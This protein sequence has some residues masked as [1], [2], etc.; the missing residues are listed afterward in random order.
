MDDSNRSAQRTSVTELLTIQELA[1]ALKIS[2]VTAY[3]MVEHRELPFFKIRGSLRFAGADVEAYLL[4]NRIES[5]ND[6]Q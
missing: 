6:W 1:K 4:R 2:T 3:R 5:K